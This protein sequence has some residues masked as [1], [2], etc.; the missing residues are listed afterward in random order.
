MNLKNIRKKFG[1]TLERG[2]IFFSII[3]LI[4]SISLFYKG[5]HN[6]DLYQN[7]LRIE[8][9]VNSAN[10]VTIKVP[11]ADEMGDTGSDYT[12]MSLT[13]WYIHGSN[14]IEYGFYGAM[15]SMAMLFFL[16]RRKL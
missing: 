5:N 4:F 14:Q 13:N 12:T 8:N 2:L 1:K 10:N 16:L 11:S 6:V 3:M 9:Y 7:Y 15:F